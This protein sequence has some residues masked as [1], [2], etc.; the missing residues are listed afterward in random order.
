VKFVDDVRIVERE[1]VLVRV[2]VEAARDRDRAFD[3]DDVVGVDGADRGADPFGQVVPLLAGRGRL[4]LVDEAEACDDRLAGVALCD[5]RPQRGQPV[6]V[7]GVGPE[8]AAVPVRLKATLR[9]VHVEDQVNAV[10]LRPRDVLVDPRPPRVLVYAGRRIVLEGPVV[11]QEARRIR[12][13]VGEPLEVDFGVVVGDSHVRP[14]LVAEGDALEEDRIAGGVDDLLAS[15]VEK[16]GVRGGGPAIAASAA[17]DDDSG[18]H[19]ERS[20]RR[21]TTSIH[22]DK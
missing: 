18:E 4:G 8:R 21:A 1:E 13:H 16:A 7:R 20:K 15:G 14:D 19:R 6:L 12:A 9:H 5:R 11:Q 22:L 2:R 10:R 3:E 17:G